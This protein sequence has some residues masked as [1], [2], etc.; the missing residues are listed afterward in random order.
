MATRLDFVGKTKAK[1]TN[2]VILALK[3]GQ[4]DL[5]PGATLRVK[6]RRDSTV[7]DKLGARWREFCYEKNGNPSKQQNVEGVPP[8]MQLTSEA[9][10]MGAV[11]LGYE[12]TGCTLVIYRGVSKLVLKDVK[13]NKL[14]VTPHEGE[15]VDVE[16]NVNTQRL[17]EDELGALAALKQHD[18]DM[19]L[20]LPEPLQ[21]TVD[22]AAKGNVVTPIKALKDSLKNEK[23]EEAAALGA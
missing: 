11:N 16:F 22:E 20:T 23:R 3:K 18:V 13:V 19:E 14:K 15:A 5:D 8:P 4:K 12:Q 2:V 9:I 1:L 6:V 21:Q 7:L 17:E 10:Q